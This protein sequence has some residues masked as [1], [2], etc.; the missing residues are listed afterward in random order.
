MEKTMQETYLTRLID[1][2]T[3][4][5]IK[6]DKLESFI[7]SDSFLDTL[8]SDKILLRNQLVVM[9]QYNEILIIRLRK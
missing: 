3:E 4:L 5:Q 7:N 1:E 2:Q 8:V 9:K 6:I